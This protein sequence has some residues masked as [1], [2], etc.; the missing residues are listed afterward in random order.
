VFPYPPVLSVASAAPPP[1]VPATETPVT[2]AE[3]VVVGA[4]LGA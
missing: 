1:A 3:A 2:G 4:A